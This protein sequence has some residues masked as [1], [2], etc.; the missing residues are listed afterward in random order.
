M[1][2]ISSSIK[3]I[4]D[5]HLHIHLDPAKKWWRVA[6]SSMI[7]I[8][9]PLSHPPYEYYLRILPVSTLIVK[10]RVKI[11]S[12]TGRRQYSK[13]LGMIEPVFGNIT[14]N[15]GAMFD[16]LVETVYNTSTGYKNRYIYHENC[17][18]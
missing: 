2:T 8:A 15:K 7:I 6:I 12:S 5:L 3:I 11:D 9:K 1:V 17:R 16:R 18:I 13:R 10:M 14:V 4:V